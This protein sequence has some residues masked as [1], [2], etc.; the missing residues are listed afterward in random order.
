MAST[1]RP[2]PTGSQVL[3]ACSVT[4][5]ASC[6]VQSV[7]KVAV[8][9]RGEWD[10]VA[11]WNSLVGHKRTV[12]AARCCCRMFHR[13]PQQEAS[14]VAA[15][16]DMSGWVRC[17]SWPVHAPALLLSIAW[18]QPGKRCGAQGAVE[19]RDGSKRPAVPLDNAPGMQLQP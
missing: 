15:L 10:R 16:G 5:E 11:A 13:G 1:A 9:T 4:G 18:L 8:L 7:H 3:K 17:P 12:V 6:G 14:N 2:M 19:L